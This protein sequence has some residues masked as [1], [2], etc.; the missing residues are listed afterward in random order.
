MSVPL[1]SGAARRRHSANKCSA[2]G[3][4][5]GGE[6]RDGQIVAGRLRKMIPFPPSPTDHWHKSNAADRGWTAKTLLGEQ[7][8]VKEEGIGLVAM[9]DD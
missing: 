1:G 2:G 6:R 9:P 4:A 7:G 8:G 5:S 3:V